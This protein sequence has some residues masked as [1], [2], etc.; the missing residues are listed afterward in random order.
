MAG[1]TIKATLDASGVQAGVSEINSSIDGIKTSGMEGLGS[2]AEGATAKVKGT[3]DGASGAGTKAL[4]MSEKFGIAGAAATVV[5]Q[6]MESG[7]TDPLRAIGK[8]SVET[9]ADFEQSMLTV[10]QLSGA[11]G[12][13]MEQLKQKATDVGNATNFSSGEA[14]QAMVMLSKAGISNSDIMNGALDATVTLATAGDMPLADA[15]TVAA[16]AMNVFHLSASDMGQVTN[17]LAFAANKSTADVKDLS[18][19]MSQCGT[20]CADA[21]WSVQETTGALGM[22]ANAGIN[23]SDAG[24]SLKQMLMSLESPSSNAKDLMDQYGVSIYNADGSMKSAGGVADNLKTAFGG[25]SEEQRNSAMATIFGSDAVRVAKLMY[26]GGA[27]G[28][29]KYTDATDDTTSAQ[30]LAQVKMEGTAGKIEQ[31]NGAIDTAKQ[32]LGDALAPVVQQ[33]CDKISDLAQKFS[34]LPAGTQTTV[35]AFAAVIAAIGPVVMGIGQFCFA[36]SSISTV[37]KAVS[38]VI[39][40]VFT[41]ISSGIRGVIAALGPVGI[42]ITIVG[43]VIAALITLWNTNEGF[44][45]A[46][47]GI[48]NAIVAAVGTA[49]N[50]VKQWFEGVVNTVVPPVKAA[51]SAVGNAIAGGLNVVT[52]VIVTVLN[53]ILSIVAPPIILIV[54]LVKAAATGIA[55]FLAPILQGI[56]DTVMSAWNAVSS[57]TMAAWSAVSN[58]VNSAIQAVLSVVVPIVDSI[59]SAVSSAWDAVSSATSAA[60]NAVTDAV[61]TAFNAALDCVTSISN[62]IGDAVSTA[63]N[64]L[65]GVASNAFNAV[66]DAIRGPLDSAKEVVSGALDAISGFFAGCVM[67]LPHINIPHISISGEFSLDP[68]SAPSFGIDWY[69][70]GGIFNSASV[71]GVG[72]AGSEAV[73]PLHGGNANP[74]AEL[75]GQA[76]QSIGGVGGTISRADLTDAIKDALSELNVAVYVDGKQLASSISGSMAISLGAMAARERRA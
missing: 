14:A 75:M 35:A 72:E 13:E 38:P 69:A 37:A 49:F 43:L 7:I 27:D 53:F 63:F 61:S 74:F 8:S 4:S 22:F 11:S 23:G 57:A 17:S 24:T 41:A 67:Q 46:V 2:S 44:R 45:N 6:S 47:I 73:V 66:V 70:T 28:L 76:I 3:G 19:G 33:T 32:K 58:A 54:T 29:A 16:N 26:E 64:A 15:S 48:W 40:M 65:G 60:W 30:D 56:A 50:A 62:A 12:D 59:S 51:V 34:D 20:M 5:G 52:N 21:G 10:Q 36:I 71:I 25:L 18:I 1:V 42:A 31:A 9:S 55:S 39:S 68:P